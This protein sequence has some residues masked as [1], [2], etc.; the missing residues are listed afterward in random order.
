MFRSDRV[1]QSA[2]TA[3]VSKK[4]WVGLC[5]AFIMMFN[6]EAAYAQTATD[7][8]KFWAEVCSSQ[9]VQQQYQCAALLIGLGHGYNEG[10]IENGLDVPFCFPAGITVA[11]IKDTFNAYLQANAELHQR[12]IAE[13]YVSSMEEAYPCE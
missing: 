4:T 3:S 1:G 5:V 10:L 9:R 2:R 7:K 13:L 12:N 6:I 11:Q 8:G